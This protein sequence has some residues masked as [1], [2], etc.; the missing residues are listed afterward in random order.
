[1]SEKINW[2]QIIK[3]QVDA[4]NKNASELKKEQEKKK[5]N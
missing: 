5:K 1:M 3:E 4:F 2:K